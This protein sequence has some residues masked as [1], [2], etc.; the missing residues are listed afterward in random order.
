MH[1]ATRV[2]RS[3]V[4]F[5]NTGKVILVAHLL[6]APAPCWFLVK[7]PRNTQADA[8]QNFYS[9]GA[10]RKAAFSIHRGR[11]NCSAVGSLRYVKKIGAWT[12]FW[13]WV[14][15]KSTTKYSVQKKQGCMGCPD[16]I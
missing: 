4:V 16:K 15:S 11:S 12:E 2:E 3:L 5:L 9:L 6:I 13:G 7:C 8:T 1:A 14:G 10:V